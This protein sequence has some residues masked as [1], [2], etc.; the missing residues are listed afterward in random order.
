MRSLHLGNVSTEALRMLTKLDTLRCRSVNQSKILDL[1]SFTNLRYLSLYA[2]DPTAVPISLV[3][4]K[5]HWCDLNNFSH[6][7]LTNLRS[8]HLEFP[9]N[10]MN[11]TTIC[12][13]IK[14]LPLEK[15]TMHD[16]NVTNAAFL[17]S[18]TNLR[19]LDIDGCWDLEGYV[20]F[21]KLRLLEYLK[22]KYCP[23]LFGII[24]FLGHKDAPITNIEDSP[25]IKQT[26]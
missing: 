4:L 10:P 9:F 6:K 12:E 3:S 18:M 23:R 21:T 22:I 1:S 5:M 24:Y 11:T 25:R 8:L 19:S 14:L 16:L 17:N 7:T 2:A 20:D 15:L 26:R 13:E